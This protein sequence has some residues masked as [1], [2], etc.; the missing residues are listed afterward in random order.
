MQLDEIASVYCHR[1]AKETTH[2][3]PSTVVTERTVIAG[4]MLAPIVA[5]CKT[6]QCFERSADAM[7]DEEWEVSAAGIYLSDSFMFSVKILANANCDCNM[8]R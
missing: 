1:H 5:I 3:S 2:K 6:T 4:L 7:H 8:L